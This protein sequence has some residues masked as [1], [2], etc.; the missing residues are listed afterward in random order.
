MEVVR[1]ERTVRRTRKRNIV[2]IP[3]FSGVK[4]IDYFCR[5]TGHGIM[6]LYGVTLPRSAVDT[7]YATSEARAR[8]KISLPEI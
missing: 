3:W 5:R 4:E 1:K 6:H 2:K 8:H 7:V